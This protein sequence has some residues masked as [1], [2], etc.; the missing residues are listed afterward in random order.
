LA[1]AL[2]AAKICTPAATG[3]SGTGL[4]VDVVVDVDAGV[5]APPPQPPISS[6]E[7]ASTVD[8]ATRTHPS[9]EKDFMPAF[10]LPAS[11]S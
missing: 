8:A 11:G 6:K 4:D 1:G 5:D 7:P 2:A 3:A 10:R 9:T